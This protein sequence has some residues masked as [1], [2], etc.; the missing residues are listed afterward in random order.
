M[1]ILDYHLPPE[2]IAFQPHDER[3]D[4]KL[5]F[6]N[7]GRIKDLVFASITSLINTDYHL[8]LN[9]TKVV[10][11]RIYFK[12]ETGAI[13][14]VFCLEPTN[15]EVTEQLT[16]TEKVRWNCMVGGAKKWK[17]GR[18]IAEATIGE[19][20]ISL[21]AEKI[22]VREGVFELE[23]SWSQPTLS[24]SEVLEIFGRVPLPPYIKRAADEHDLRRYQT[25]FA[26]NEGSVA[27]PTASLHFTDKI[28][29]E[30]TESG[31]QLAKV[32]LH[33]GAGTFKPISSSV[34]AHEMHHELFEVE[35]D[36]LKK[37]ASLDDLIAVGT[38]AVR[39]VESLFIL[40]NTLRNKETFDLSQAQKVQQWEWRDQKNHFSSHKEAF[41]F[42]VDALKQSNL[43]KVYGYTS[44]MILPGFTFNVIKGLITNFHMPKSTLLLLVSAFIG[45]DWERVYKHALSSEYSFL[46]YGDSSLLIP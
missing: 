40:A 4:S 22:E 12:K 5:L 7:Q 1:D 24:F 45:D 29:T 19:K 13:I 39:T 23:F 16:L 20:A 41:L 2:R 8:I 11:A 6:Y 15:G 37:L 25:V 44:L 33:V 9:E 35:I 36:E 43:D 27:A 38:T 32:N 21:Y 31:V 3:S 10:N 26:Q 42:L 34:E 46:S 17:G 14:E 30:L 18:I 28:L